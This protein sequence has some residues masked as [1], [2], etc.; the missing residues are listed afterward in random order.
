MKCIQVI[1]SACVNYPPEH[2]SFLLPPWPRR[3][4]WI[5]VN[6]HDNAVA[7]RHLDFASIRQISGANF[8]VA[9]LNFPVLRENALRCQCDFFVVTSV[10]VDVD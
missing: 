10:L 6:H 4:L 3:R 9:A 1:R 2:P 8:F 7:S 5:D